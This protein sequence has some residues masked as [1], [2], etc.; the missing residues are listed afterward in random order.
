MTLEEILAYAYD[1]AD[2]NDW[3]E[4]YGAVSKLIAQNRKHLKRQWD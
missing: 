3:D 1:I 2:Y 4:W